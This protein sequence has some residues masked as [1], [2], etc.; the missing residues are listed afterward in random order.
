MIII[1]LPT[2]KISIF[3]KETLVGKIVHYFGKMSVAVINLHKG[4]LKVGDKIHIK[5]AHDDFEEIVS[6][7]QI[8]HKP[9][10]SAKKGQEVAIKVKAK[11]H[12]NDEV[13]VVTE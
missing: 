2:D 5:G 11:V 10:E 3:M 6:S 1:N 4:G 7:M 13:F 9:V 8:D 12:N